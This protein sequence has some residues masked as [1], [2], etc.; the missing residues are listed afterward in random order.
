MVSSATEQIEKSHVS[1]SK[2]FLIRHACQSTRF[3]LLCESSLA[4]PSLLP[5]KPTTVQIIQSAISVSKDHLKKGQDMVAEVTDSVPTAHVNH[6]TLILICLEILAYSDHRMESASH[7]LT[8]GKVKDARA[9]MSAA[10]A[11]QKG[12]WGN[13]KRINDTMS[14]AHVM[15]SLEE[16]TRLSS[17]ALSMMVAY[18]N[19]GEDTLSWTP[20]KTERD[21]F[22]E[23]R[24]D[25]AYS[26]HRM[27]SASHA[28]TQGKVKDA[29]AWMSAALAYQKGSWGALKR[30]NDTMSIAHVMTSLDELTRL[31]SNALSMMVAYDNNGEDT[32]SWTPP[33]TER[34]GFYEDRPGQ[35]S[36]LRFEGG[37]P[38]NLKVDITVC[39]DH[40]ECYKTVQA[41]VDAA[42]ENAASHFVIKIRSGVYRETVRIAIEKKNLVF[43]GEGIGKT[44]I[45]GSLNV[46]QPGIT[47]FSS[48]T[49]G[50]L[51]DGFM[52]RD[53]T[54]ENTAGS[55]ADQAVAFRS[56]SDMS[57]IEN[58]E[59]IGNQDTLSANSLRQFYRN[60][61]IQGNVDFIFGTAAS[62]FQ[63]CLLLVAPR[64][65]NPEEGD[66]NAITAQG[67][68]DPAESTGFVFHHCVIIGTEE[69]MKIYNKNPQV[70]KN[71]LGRPWKEYSRT[72][73]IDCN[74]EKLIS[75]EGWTTWSGDTGL[76]TLFY[77]EFRNIGGGSDFSKRVPWSTQI[78]PQFVHAYSVE[79]FIQGDQWIPKSQ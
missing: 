54:V 13:I 49:V 76:K 46:H 78:P 23:D 3:P 27:E 73:F 74:I 28:L 24:P 71:Y 41:A 70:H 22:Y 37:V 52:A 35:K 12:S 64:T 6:T 72:V 56:D 65:S 7:A 58:C 57:V 16:L 19:N 51:G 5:P 48:A 61:S 59:F 39:K 50:V 79:N 30:I 25:V 47:T 53:L 68:T 15:T 32:L 29:R 17:N 26:D 40:I 43:W 62:V 4:Q 20:P 63:D 77:G 42:P 44:I 60:C 18:D 14:I 38:T 21:G 11:Y 69:Y 31:S 34:D 55:E 75:P 1:I 45:T 36:E 33:K 8:Q 10:L 66:N 2:L 67:R 9:W